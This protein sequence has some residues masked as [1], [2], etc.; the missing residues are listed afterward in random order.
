M[1]MATTT[2]RVNL[3][4]LK[5]YQFEAQFPDIPSAPPVKFDEPLPLGEGTAPQAVDVLSAAIG[6]CLA[7]SLAF[8]LRKARVA[9]DGLEAHVTTEV[10]RDAKGRMRIGS[11]AVELAPEV[12]QTDR[13]GLE[14]CKALFEDFCTVTASVRRG[15]DVGVT[16]KEPALAEV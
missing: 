16:V 2:H 3:R 1:A 12:S 9:F 10:T 11:I 7:A 15:I 5:N 6:N 4:M 8:C 13:A 14:R